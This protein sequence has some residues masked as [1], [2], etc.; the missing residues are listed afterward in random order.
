MNSLLK[1]QIDKEK[2]LY[3]FIKYYEAVLKKEQEKIEISLTGAGKFKIRDEF[4]Q[5]FSDTDPISNS[6]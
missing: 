2:H 6:Y 1:Y 5:V 3:E 4:F